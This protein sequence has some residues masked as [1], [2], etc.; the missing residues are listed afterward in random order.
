MVG[1]LV[2]GWGLGVV[3]LGWV[4]VGWNWG[5]LMQEGQGLEKFCAKHARE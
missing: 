1:G 4:G 5:G 2:D 3:G